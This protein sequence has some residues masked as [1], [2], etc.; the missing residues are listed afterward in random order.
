M[1][2]TKDNPSV[3][4]CT[5]NCGF[6]VVYTFNEHLKLK[7]D[8]ANIRPAELSRRSGVTKQ[9]I[10]RLINNTP[11]SQTGAPARAEKDTVIR[12]ARALD[13]DLND[14]LKSADFAPETDDPPKART[15]AEFIDGLEKLG[16]ELPGWMA[17]TDFSDYTEDDFEG[18]KAQII[19][20]IGVRVRPKRL[21]E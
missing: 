2:Y 9:N 18:L 10:G 14:A 4:I 7:L 20:D 17:D 12:L 6:T 16:L 15:F 1:I 11:H 19:A 3:T 5:V 13:W 21:P 8:E